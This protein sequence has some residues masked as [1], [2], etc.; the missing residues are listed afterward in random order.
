MAIPLIYPIVAGVLVGLG[1]LTSSKKSNLN[2]L[3]N[4]KSDCHQD[5]LNFDY[6][7]MVND[8]KRLRLDTARNAIENKIKNYF[9]ELE[10]YIVPKFYLHGSAKLGTQIRTHDDSCDYDIGIYFFKKPPHGFET[11]QNHIKNALEGHTS[12]EIN[13]RNKC[14]RINYKNDFH[15]DMP[16]FYTED[17]RHFYL[18]SKGNKWN[19]CDAKIF[20]DWFLDK[21]EG[22]EQIIRIIKYFKAWS[23]KYQH[24]MPSGLAFT[25]WVEKYY[26][27]H[28]R[29]DIAFMLTASNLLKNLNEGFWSAK[30]WECIMPVLPH[31]DLLYQ[32]DTNQK[33]KFK[34]TLE[35]L[36]EEG[37]DALKSNDYEYT[38]KIW[39]KQLGRWFIFLIFYISFIIKT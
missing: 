16:I 26:L 21:T 22:N 13:L 12:C 11:I 19:K 23:D 18:G 14:V 10:Q 38:M 17:K 33:Y 1:I 9:R 29:D 3:D 2:D 5:F 24:K 7:L 15:I 28:D 31:D 30:Y 6:N 27:E 8:S 39:K 36:I 32:L 4:Y 37:F 34:E 35:N 25:V 20:R